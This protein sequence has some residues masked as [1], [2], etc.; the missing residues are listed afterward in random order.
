MVKFLDRIGADGLLHG[1]V[2]LVMCALL[3][4]LV[5][6]LWAVLAT[7]AAGSVKELLWD[8]ALKKGSPSWKDFLC[9]VTG[10]AAGLVLALIN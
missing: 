5:P 1:L 8:W 6:W 7:V 3:C 9:D 4:A 2:S 10:A